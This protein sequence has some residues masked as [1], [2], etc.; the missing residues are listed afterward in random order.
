MTTRR[1]AAAAVVLV[2]LVAAAASFVKAGPVLQDRRSLVPTAK[3]VRGPL[4][5]TVYATGDLRA[6][7]TVNLMAPSVGGQIRI[8]KLLTTGTP[9]K[10]GD[11]VMEFDP[12]D[13][14]FALEQAQVDLESA[15]QQI[16]KMKA[17][18]AVQRSQD[19]L[20]LVT[21]QYDV[22][23]AE[24][25]VLGNEFVGAIDAQKNQLTLDEA[26]HRL[27]QLQQ[28]AAS[29]LATSAAALDVVIEKRNKADLA[30]KRAQGIIDNLAVK[31]SIDGVVSVKENRDGQ[32]FYYNG[33]T[34]PE[35]RE[36]DTTFSGRNVAD[37][38]E[39]GKMEAHAKITE[40]DRDNLQ[41]GQSAV[42]QIDALP[43]R[44][45]EAKVGALTGSASRGNFFETSAVRQFDIALALDHPD[46]QMRAGSSLRVTIDGREVKNAVHVPRQ[47]VFEKNGKNFVYVQV[48]DRFDRRDIK[49]ENATESRA[50][51][52]GLT[53][54]D[55]IALVD[56]DLALQKGKA[57]S[58]PVSGVAGK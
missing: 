53:E 21:A 11:V 44:T 14:Q 30:M 32:M 35:Y 26:K 2:I 49:V 9:V 31:S 29:R 23:K 12:S 47:A 55:V 13:Q 38:I 34:L 54:G 46:P 43:G 45:F 6:G 4:K 51:V 33:M 10:A 50:I 40:T 5:L 1:I 52:S 3:V 17:D 41:Q 48:G 42:I 27:Q 16:V 22:R 8:V 28:D 57:S 19:K 58:G 56:P 15:E 7:R 18:N 39:Q 25:D 37:V 36:G 20:N 24:L